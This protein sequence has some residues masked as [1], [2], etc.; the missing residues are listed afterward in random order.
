MGRRS[1]TQT[2]SLWSNGLRVGSWSMLRDGSAQLEYDPAW[3]RSPKG[4]PI[5]ISLPF[6]VGN[7]VHKGPTVLNYFDNLL[8]D[9]PDIRKRLGSRFKTDSLEAFDL[10][11]SVGRDCVG[12]LQILGE[13][14][15][16]KDVEHI[17]ATAL[18]EFEVEHLLERASSAS[19]FGRDDADEHDLRISLAGMQDK[20]AL[21]YWKG[22]W[23][24]PEGA[25]PTTHILKMPLGP[26]G[27]RQVDFSRSVDNEWLCLAL[28]RAFGVDAAQASIVEFGKFRV[29]AVE[30]FDRAVS[31]NGR[32]LLR[33]P[34]EDFCQ[35]FG[36]PPEKKYEADGGPGM[37]DLA[38][39]LHQSATP[40]HDLQMLLKAQLLFWM[41][42]A[43]DGHAKNF[44]IALLAGGRF[45]LTPLYDVMSAWPV[46]GK[47]SHHWHSRDLKLAMALKGKNKH[48]ACDQIAR[49]HF[50]SA[51]RHIRYA[52]N[53]D[54]IVEE[55]LAS[56]ELAIQ[57]VESKLPAGLCEHVTEKIFEG[58]RFS[59][60]RL[61]GQPS[62]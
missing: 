48:Y 13:N 37:E 17:T 61:G 33:L 15:E 14:E 54:H 27:R 7:Q 4:R 30:R 19:G 44:S 43:T 41:L 2:L 16:P 25:T 55:T 6:L 47:G 40:E 11:R 26:I 50:N 32:W 36:L 29:L 24:R 49:R 38:S 39:V 21:L 5:S 57:A 58:L 23:R 20:T 52:Q 31:D 53:M 3:M 45:Q 60:K 34:Q 1:H 28:L 10:L 62:V 42:R 9:N 51:A 59:A 12:A 56:V 46:V 22:K 18:S 35:V 8:P